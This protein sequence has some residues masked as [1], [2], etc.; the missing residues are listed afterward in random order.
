[1]MFK[2]KSFGRGEIAQITS[3]AL[4]GSSIVNIVVLERIEMVIH[5][6]ALYFHISL[7]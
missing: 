4:F 2:D 6:M 5:S 3:K 1:M 7:L